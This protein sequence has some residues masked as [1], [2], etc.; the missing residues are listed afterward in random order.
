MARCLFIMQGI[1]NANT[2]KMP[3]I[4]EILG[5][6]LHSDVYYMLQEL[7]V[8]VA[9]SYTRNR[10]GNQYVAISCSMNGHRWKLADKCE[11]YWVQWHTHVHLLN[12]KVNTDI[13]RHWH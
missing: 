11:I 9:T 8:H 4:H 2:H 13:L 6:I 5:N 7:D 12:Y 1:N 3:V 10:H